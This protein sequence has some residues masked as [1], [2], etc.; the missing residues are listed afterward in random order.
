MTEYRIHDTPHQILANR[1]PH[2]RAS[3]TLLVPFSFKIS[4]KKVLKV[5][6]A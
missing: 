3:L 5:E 6:N 1:E 4:Q 2:W